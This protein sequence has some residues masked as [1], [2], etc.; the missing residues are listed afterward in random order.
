MKIKGLSGQFNS[1]LDEKGRILLPARLREQLDNFELV[2]TRGVE[3]CLWLFP[4]EEWERVSQTLLKHSS[5]FKAKTQMI[6]RRLL[7]PATEMVTDKNGRVKVPSSL[8]KSAGLVRDCVFIGLR[9]HI[10]IWDEEL[11]IAF[12]E[13]CEKD[14]KNAWEEMGNLEESLI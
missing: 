6:H 3:K 4:S 10:E 13:E 11:Y 7:A 8:A 14:V 2:L 5:L 9:D 1:T 12:E